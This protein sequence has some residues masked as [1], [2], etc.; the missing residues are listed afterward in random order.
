MEAMTTKLKFATL[1]FGLALASATCQTFAAEPITI[2]SDQSQILNMARTPGTVVVG[3]PSIADVTIQGKQVFLH[4]KTYGTTNITILDETGGQLGM[5]E[6]TVQ[7]GGSNNV[8]LFKAGA[9]AS[10]VC[11][12]DCESSLH[13]G[14]EKDYF[15][16]LVTQANAKIGLAT[17]QK[18]GESATPP[19]QPVQ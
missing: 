3:N 7:L 12:P 15:K 1:A 19:P 8:A 5:F 14:D 13:I 2:L 10:Y 11:A 6:V 9:L 4:G 17:G 18:S 16:N